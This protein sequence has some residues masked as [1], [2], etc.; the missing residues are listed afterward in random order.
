MS[1]FAIVTGSLLTL[2][3]FVG[4]APAEPV[5][6]GPQPGQKVPGPF[7][8]LH[9][10][11]PDAGNQ[12]CLYCKNGAHP[13]A[14]VFAREVSAPLVAL[15][16]KLDAATAEHKDC[17]MGSFVV[18][19][20]DSA[21]LPKTLKKI[22]DKEHIQ[23]TIFCTDAPAGPPTYQVAGDADV[24]VILY[25]LHTVKANYAFRKGELDD[26]ATAAILADVTRV[27]PAP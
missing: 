9:V 11:G 18:F 24:T 7:H 6:S 4:M 15:L 10:T 20:N 2:T 21:E 26:K 19:L 16:K 27:L 23:T 13:V 8:P 25:T 22:A 1:K 14:L 17:Q 5:K 12:V 3:A